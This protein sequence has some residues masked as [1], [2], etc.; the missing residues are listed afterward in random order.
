MGREQATPWGHH[1][2]LQTLEGLVSRHLVPRLSRFPLRPRA[3]S[4]SEG[5]HPEWGLT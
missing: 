3:D 5:P 1:L 4:S 2:V